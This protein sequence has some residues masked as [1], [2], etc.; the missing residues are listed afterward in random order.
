M[1][2]LR[3]PFQQKKNVLHRKKKLK[4]KI[5]EITNT[6]VS[7]N[8]PDEFTVI[9]KMQLVLSPEEYIIIADLLQTK[10][11]VLENRLDKYNKIIESGEE[12]EQDKNIFGETQIQL[13]T[14]EN[15]ISLTN[16]FQRS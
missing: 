9:K 8:C 3:P 7:F 10:L 6:E 14:V 11:K 1:P 12:T 5:S 2:G 4:M 16:H 15:F 13:D